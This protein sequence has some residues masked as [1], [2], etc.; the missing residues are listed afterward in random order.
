MAEQWR[1]PASSERLITH[2]ASMCTFLPGNKAPDE[3]EVFL[4]HGLAHAYRTLA[5]EGPR[6]FYEGQIA[7]AILSTSQDL[8]G[9]MTK[10]DLRCF[11]AEWVD[12]ISIDYAEYYGNGASVA[13]WRVHSGRT[14]QAH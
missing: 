11:A 10:E 6:A 13:R 7:D 8:G 1:A 12:P 14:A 4:N 3:G 2:P 5:K 9:T